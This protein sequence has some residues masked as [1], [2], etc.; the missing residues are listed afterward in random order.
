V[1]GTPLLFVQTAQGFRA[2]KVTLVRE[3]AEESLV[4]GE[5]KGDERVAVRGVAAL[6]AA[7]SGI[8]GE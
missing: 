4:G 7:L 6:K 5:I 2:Q 3:G 1:E 8:G